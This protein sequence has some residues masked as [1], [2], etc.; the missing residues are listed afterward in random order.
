MALMPTTS[1]LLDGLFSKV[2]V[3]EKRLCEKPVTAFTGLPKKVSGCV[4]P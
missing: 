1:L 4:S 2:G 3:E